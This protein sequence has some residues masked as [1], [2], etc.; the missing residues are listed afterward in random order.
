MMSEFE[1]N[2]NRLIGQL[3]ALIPYNEQERRDREVMLDALSLHPKS[4]FLRSS[5]CAHMTASAW[6]ISP[7]ADHV[8]MAYHNIYHAWSWLGGHADG[9]TDLLAVAL[10]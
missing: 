7:D 5:L 3:K 10:R 6:V 8:L 9:E 1:T 4:V 2:L